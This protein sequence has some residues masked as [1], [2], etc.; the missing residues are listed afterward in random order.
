MKQSLVRFVPFFLTVTIHLNG[1]ADAG[2]LK[3]LN[4]EL[5]ALVTETEPY[6]VTVRGEYNRRSLVASG[7]VFNGSGHVITSAQLYRAS[8]FQVE[9]RNGRRYSATKIGVDRISGIAVLKLNGSGFTS[10]K[11]KNS[12]RLSPG[13]WITVIGNSYEIPASLSFGS[14]AGRTE[15]GFLKLAVNASPGS[16]G[17]A[18]MNLD[19][20]VVGVLVARDGSLAPDEWADDSSYYALSPQ[21]PNE[22]FIDRLA[23]PGGTCY[24]IPIETALENAGRLIRDGRI[25]RGYL[26]I[27]TRNLSPITQKKLGIDGGVTVVD[28]EAGSPADS[29]GLKKGDA[30]VTVDGRS[31]SSR[32][33]LFSQVRSHRPGETIDI[34]F[35]RNGKMTK[36]AA[37]L[38]EARD[39]VSAYSG[40]TLTAP[41][42]TSDRMSLQ[43]DSSW[44]AELLKLRR[45]IIQLQ[46]EVERLKKEIS[47]QAP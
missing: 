3:S 39:V 43:N 21:R 15:D 25:V 28:I 34:G 6:L 23:R 7:L 8:N 30:I 32:S 35:L 17:A 5:T 14:F 22:Q 41:L 4:Q 29:A 20:E 42:L 46:G 40:D 36:V 1:Q 47:R 33:A 11:M 45:E 2:V 10:P 31:I 13:A 26:G 27:S 38:S 24:A 44:R 16:S 37:K 19:G 9:L 12:T 18:V